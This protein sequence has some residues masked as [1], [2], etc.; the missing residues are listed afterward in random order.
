MKKIAATIAMSALAATGAEAREK[1]Q[2]VAPQAVYETAPGLGD[3]TDNVLFGEVWERKELSPRDRSLV[4]VATLVSTGKIAQTGSHLRRALDNGVKPEEIG[5]LITQLAFYSGWPNAMSAVVETKKVFE[6]RGIGALANSDA[7][8]IELEAAAEAARATTV[9]ANV[10]PTA[11]ALADLTNRV[12]FGDLWQRP[13]LSARDRSLVTM[14]ALVA[15]GQPEQ[16]PFHANRAMDNG[17]TRA[18]ASEVVTQVAFYAGW[19]RAMS[20]VPVL[21]KAFE[22]REAA[23]QA[24][25]APADLKVTRAGEGRAAAP[26]QY[27][28]G[29]VETS[30][31]YRGDAPAR[32]GG[33]TVSFSAGA[34]TAW[35]THPLGQTLFIMSGRGLVQKQG[36][37]VEEVGPGDVVW[38]PPQVRHWH[39]ASAEEAMTHFAVAEA[40]DG[41]SVT[42]ME[43]VS[44]EDYPAGRNLD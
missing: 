29:K 2:R 12:L 11:S 17:L 30:G 7:A 40:L 26:E 42:W 5:E 41:N 24:A 21:K 16:L 25:T 4:T 22:G 34:R 10:A 13:D 27:F 23:S 28:T 37:A 14:A 38:I 9:D 36:G 18:E 32:I 15:I 33:A 3:F 35:H 8:R 19:P 44:D 1:R 20:A 31:F 6:E 43:K 39:G